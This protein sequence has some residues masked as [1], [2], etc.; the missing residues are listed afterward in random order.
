M[1]FALVHALSF[2][3]ALDTAEEL[4]VAALWVFIDAAVTEDLLLKIGMAL[5]DFEEVVPR[6]LRQAVLFSSMC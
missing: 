4:L 2:N 1:F 6:A 3:K 5:D